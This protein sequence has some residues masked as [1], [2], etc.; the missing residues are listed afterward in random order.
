[1]LR[2]ESCMEI[3]ILKQQGKSER[4]IS[5]LTG[6][7]RTT[8]RKYLA[9]GTV[10]AYQARPKRIGKLDP[11][12]DYIRERIVANRPHRLP[13]TVLYREIKETRLFW[14]AAY[15]EYICCIAL[16]ATG[17]GIHNPLRNPCWT[18]NAG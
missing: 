16:P 10:P 15:P 5:R 14:G 11:F 9:S 4:E 1:M 12:K 17:S 2:E 6:H 18:A 7:S 3:R 13:A 8:I